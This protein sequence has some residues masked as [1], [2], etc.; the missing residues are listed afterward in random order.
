MRA[1]TNGG[2]GD[3]AYTSVRRSPGRGTLP[4]AVR[5][6]GDLTKYSALEFGD[7]LGIGLFI[8]L[9]ICALLSFALIAALTQGRPPAL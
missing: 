8:G 1:S 3:G 5:A 9:G 2:S 4:D 6:P 7:L